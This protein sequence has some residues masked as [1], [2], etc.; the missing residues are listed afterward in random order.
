[1]TEY[2]STK[3]SVCCRSERKW[4]DQGTGNRGEGRSLPF[5]LQFKTPRL[6][7][8][9]VRQSC[10]IVVG[11]CQCG[12]ITVPIVRIVS[13]IRS[14]EAAILSPFRMPIHESHIQTAVMRCAK[15]G[16]KRL[17]TIRLPP[18]PNPYVA[19]FGDDNRSSRTSSLGADHI[20]LGR[21]LTP[22]FAFV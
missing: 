20:Q 7:T 11:V 3:G 12:G 18:V 13:E 22:R 8:G 19:G 4:L 10:V 2:Y 5:S 9:C 16:P 14:G 6:P 15:A 17:G 21:S 1:M